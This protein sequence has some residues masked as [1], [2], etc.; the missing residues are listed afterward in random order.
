MSFRVETAGA[1]AA[2]LLHR[3]ALDFLQALV[4]DEFR[5][6]RRSHTLETTGRCVV[7]RRVRDERA[8]SAI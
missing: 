7:R 8:A 2:A 6:A 3:P 4:G 1:E 5:A